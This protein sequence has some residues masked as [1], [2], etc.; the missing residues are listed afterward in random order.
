M[1]KKKKKEVL[2]DT[3]HGHDRE[4]QCLRSVMPQLRAPELE[5]LPS[6]LA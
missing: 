3:Q 6:G 1:K 2:L 5:H 4:P